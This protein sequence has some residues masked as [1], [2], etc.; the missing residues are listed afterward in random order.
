MEEYVEGFILLG[1]ISAQLI[2]KHVYHSAF[3]TNEYK[4][5]LQPAPQFPAGV[6]KFWHYGIY[7]FGMP[8]LFGVNGNSGQQLDKPTLLSVL[9]DHGLEP[10]IS[11]D[12][13]PDAVIV[14]ARTFEEAER[15]VQPRAVDAYGHFHRTYGAEI[16]PR[17]KPSTTVAQ[18]A[19]TESIDD[20][21]ESKP[22]RTY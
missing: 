1:V 2:I 9:G 16:M 18:K 7:Y 17:F 8:A 15:E 10:I 12:S 22:V 19:Q 13:E 4:F 11:A 21:I 6:P 14:R 5:S 3:R 20:V